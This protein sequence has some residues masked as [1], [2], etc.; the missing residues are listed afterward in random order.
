MTL[1]RKVVLVPGE[2]EHKVG[3][4]TLAIILA[5][6][7][8][9]NVWRGQLKISRMLD[10]THLQ[11][12]KRTIDVWRGQVKISRILGQGDLSKWLKASEAI[13]EAAPKATE[14]IKVFHA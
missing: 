1:T 6:K 11:S 4:D 14:R 10:Q 9:I 7:R 5:S 8:T 3:P 12:L 2:G 13:Y